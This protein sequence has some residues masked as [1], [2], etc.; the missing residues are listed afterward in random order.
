MA[1]AE[2]EQGHRHR[3]DGW[4]PVLQLIGVLLGAGVIAAFMW[5]SYV[6]FRSNKDGAGFISMLPPLAA[7][8]SAIAW[9]F[10]RK[11]KPS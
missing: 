10:R 4:V 9:G 5:L 7:L 1:M 2:R 6:L 11:S 8:F 3:M